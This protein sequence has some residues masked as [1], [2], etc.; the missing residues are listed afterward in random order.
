[1]RRV[2]E[3]IALRRILRRAERRRVARE[4]EVEAANVVRMKAWL[5]IRSALHRLDEVDDR[6][7]NH[8]AGRLRA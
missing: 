3:Q 7:A 4:R 6:R 2:R 5:D 1:M 8:P